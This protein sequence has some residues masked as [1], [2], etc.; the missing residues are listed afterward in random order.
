MSKGRYKVIRYYA[1]P[2]YQEGKRRMEE[3]IDDYYE[4]GWKPYGITS[5]KEM[6]SE[7]EELEYW[8]ILY[9]PRVDYLMK[10]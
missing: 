4:R 7:G 10:Q 1:T 3:D 5:S 9:G 6:L 8:E 2:S